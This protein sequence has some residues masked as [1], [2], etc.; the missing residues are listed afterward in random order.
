VWRQRLSKAIS[1]SNVTLVTCTSGSCLAD[2]ISK[3]KDKAESAIYLMDYELLGQQKNGLDL[4]SEHNI[5]QQAIL[6]TS[7][8]EESNIKN[9][10]AQFGVKLI[11]KGMAPL[12]PIRVEKQ[13]KKVD[14]VL[15]DN[16]PLVAMM[17]AL[18]AKE[19]NKSVLCFEGESEFDQAMDEIDK[20][21]PIY[22]D[23]D[24]GNGIKGQDVAGRLYNKGFRNISLATGFEASSVTKPEF[25]SA[26]IGKDFP[27]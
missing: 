27:L 3:N 4:I 5:A 14:G 25:I 11:P 21:S 17:W 9:R 7:R 24:L 13:A 8:Y 10:C 16:D 22:V 19:K 15:I 6:V 23:V 20:T 12:V 18:G 2:W 1:T 26:I